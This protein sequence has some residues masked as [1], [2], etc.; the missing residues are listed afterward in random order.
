MIQWVGS[1]DLE[2]HFIVTD[3]DT[4]I[5]IENA[6]IDVNPYGGLYDERDKQRFTLLADREGVAMRL[7]QNG[8]CAGTRSGLR[9]TD[10]HYVYPP[11]WRFQATAPGYETGEWTDLGNPEFTDKVRVVGPDAS[12]LVIPIRLRPIHPRN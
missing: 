3:E 8:T 6:K 9:L 1:I 11:C 12:R 5:P 2:V 10:T 4:R 7:C